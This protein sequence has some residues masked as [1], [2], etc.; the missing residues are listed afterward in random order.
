M[1]GRTDSKTVSTGFKLCGFVVA[2]SLVVVV[3]VLLS[4]AEDGIEVGEKTGLD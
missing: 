4:A 2:G 3:V 1:S